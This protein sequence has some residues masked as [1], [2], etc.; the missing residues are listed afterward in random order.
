VPLVIDFI[1]HSRRNR[2]RTAAGTGR[3]GAE[4]QV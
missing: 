2:A 3:D 1:P 4:G